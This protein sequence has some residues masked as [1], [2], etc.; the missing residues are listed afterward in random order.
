MYYD[1][2]ILCK[3]SD[4]SYT[5]KKWC[6]DS[7]AVIE[8]AAETVYLFSDSHPVNAS[9]ISNFYL[10]IMAGIY[11]ISFKGS[12]IPYHGFPWFP[13][14]YYTIYTFYIGIYGFYIYIPF[15]YC[16]CIIMF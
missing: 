5:F 15:T 14:N 16:Y 8:L 10:I 9:I 13:P 4:F 12:T 3:H 7:V 11:P 6:D 2:H 1:K